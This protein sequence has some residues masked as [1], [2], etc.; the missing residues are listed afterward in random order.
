MG[1]LGIIS[2]FAEQFR[3]ASAIVSGLYFDIVGIYHIIKKPVSKNEKIAM[4][5]DIFI[6]LVMLIFILQL[7]LIQGS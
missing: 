6:F 7:T 2:L 5:P 3:L 4:V 1:L